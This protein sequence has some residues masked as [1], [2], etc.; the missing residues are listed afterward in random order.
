MI[1]FDQDEESLTLVARDYGAF[2]VTT[3]PGSVRNLL[4]QK[5]KF[6]DFDFVYAAGLYDYLTEPVGKRLVE[7]MFESLRPGGK[8]LIANFMHDIPDVGYMESFMDWW[9]IYRDEMQMR[10]LFNSLPKDACGEVQT[11]TDPLQNI[12]FATVEKNK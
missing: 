7:I 8:M 10:A 11:F 4:S 2:G 3:I 5:Q 9:L 1:A 12:I 6:S